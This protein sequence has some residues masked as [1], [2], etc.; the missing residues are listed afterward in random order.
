MGYFRKFFDFTCNDDVF[1]EK[2]TEVGR[3][4]VGLVRARRKIR[5]VTHEI[6][7]MYTLAKI[8]TIRVTD[9]NLGGAVTNNNNTASV[10]MSTCGW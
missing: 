1:H 2:Y 6:L 9:I 7:I 8:S 3:G 4:Y 5:E 10:T